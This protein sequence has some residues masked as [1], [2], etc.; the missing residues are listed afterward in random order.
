MLLHAAVLACALQIAW[1]L[2]AGHLPALAAYEEMR[3][4]L[5]HLLLLLQS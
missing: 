3:L 5:L 1:S 4:P 2:P